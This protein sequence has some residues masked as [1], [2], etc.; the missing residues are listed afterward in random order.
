[1]ELSARYPWSLAVPIRRH[2]IETTAADLEI[3]AQGAGVGSLEIGTNFILDAG[4][5]HG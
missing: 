1:L 3:E 2:A 5:R 4:H